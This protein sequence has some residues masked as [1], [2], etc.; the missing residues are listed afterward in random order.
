M[1]KNMFTP[2]KKVGEAPQGSNEPRSGKESP[3]NEKKQVTAEAP[4]ADTVDLVP[5]LAI[6]PPYLVTKDGAFVMMFE[7]PPLESSATDKGSERAFWSSRYGTALATLPPGTQF[8]MSVILEPCDPTS[9]LQYFLSRAEKWHLLV[10]DPAKSEQERATAHALASASD[11]ITAAI[12]DWYDSARPVNMRTILT[13]SWRPSFQAVKS[14]LFGANSKTAT[15]TLDQIKACLPQAEAALTEKA[16]LLAAAFLGVSIPLRALSYGEMCQ[17]VWRTLHPAASG[18][19]SQSAI[20]IAEVLAKGEREAGFGGPPP[21]DIFTPEMTPDQLAE[22]L[23]PDTF[24]EGEDH[25]EVDGVYASGYVIHDFRPNQ[26]AYVGRLSDLPGGWCGTMFV[27]IADPAIV[28]DRLRQRE[29][30]LQAKEMAKASKGLLADFGSRQEASAVQTARFGLETSS[31]AP[32]YIRFFV[33]R[34]ANDLETLQKRTRD[35]ESLLKTIGIY[36][37]CAR[38][39][40]ALLYQSFLPVNSQ[41]LNQKARNM[42]PDAL[43]TFFWP[44]HRRVMDEEGIY[45]GLDMDTNL[46]VRIDPF[47]ARSDKTPSYLAIGRP[48]AGKSVWLRAMMTSAMLSGGNVMA[49]DLEGEMEGFARMY[50]GRYIEVGTGAGEKINILDIPPDSEDP[51]SAG[52]EHLVSFCGAV[53]GMPIPHGAEWNALASAYMIA[54]QDRGW[55]GEGFSI[56]EWRHEDAPRLSDIVRILERHNAS[57]GVSRSLADMLRPYSEGVYAPYFN[58]STSFDIRNERLV[59]FGLKNVNEDQSSIRLRVYLWQVMGL[60]W[61]EVLRR[62]AVEPE[63]ANHIMLDEVWKLLSSPGGAPA[64]ENMARRFRKRKASLWMATQEVGEF[65]DTQEGRK[66]LSIVGNTFL[67]DQRPTEAERLQLALKLSPGVTRYLSS[68]GTGRGL[69]LTPAATLHIYVAV[70]DAWNVFTRV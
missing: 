31:V 21:V 13:I 57:D 17:V 22:A 27:E 59:I 36:H 5:I 19:K 66:I 8:Q 3:R 9:D 18:A 55:L 64:I 46:P 14:A 52:T 1:L 45:I 54:I 41:I 35:L 33:I 48:G 56:K 53:R 23:A 4:K 7:I 44:E 26:P 20:H 67:M 61:S 2:R 62:H 38:Y 43:S 37:F 50:G 63:V 29:V 70:P 49:I 16:S 58:T 42:T 40:Q 68:L 28:A 39:S 12:A 11:H 34:T 25:F 69:L 24:V 30:Q 32:I 10:G 60:I 65:I 51:L 15:V 47:G 6:V